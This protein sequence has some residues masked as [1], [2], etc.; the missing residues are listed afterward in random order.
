MQSVPSRM[1]TGEDGSQAEYPLASNVFLR[2]PFGKLEASGSCCT[3]A[4]PLNL[5]NACPSLTTMNA[6]CF[7]AVASVRGWKRWV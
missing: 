3:S 7:S 4:L 6:S 1:N 2:P 5:S